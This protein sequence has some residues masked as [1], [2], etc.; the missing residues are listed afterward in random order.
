MG[1]TGATRL[2]KLFQEGAWLI[3]LGSWTSPA[4]L[5]AKQNQG[6]FASVCLKLSLSLLEY[7]SFPWGLKQMQGEQMQN[8]PRVGKATPRFGSGGCAGEQTA[9]AEIRLCSLPIKPRRYPQ[10]HNA[11]FLVLSLEATRTHTHT[12]THA[13]TSTHGHKHA[14]PSAQA[15]R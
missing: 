11:N 13:Q 10:K 9:R 2:F 7:F 5:R 12:H 6:S 4:L 1:S 15:H 8:Q 3:Y 14:Q